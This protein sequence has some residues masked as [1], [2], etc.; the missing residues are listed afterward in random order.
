MIIPFQENRFLAF[1]D[2]GDQMT[3]FM[4]EPVKDDEGRW[5][6]E[7]PARDS[8]VLPD[9]VRDIFSVII[10]PGEKK[11]IKGFDVE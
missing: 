7:E 2:Q 6:C 5:G 8:F 9:G 1:D 4:V 10:D 3:L 11:T